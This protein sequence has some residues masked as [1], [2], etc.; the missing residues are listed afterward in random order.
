MD[1]MNASVSPAPVSRDRDAVRDLILSILA[2]GV[3][4]WFVG[5]LVWLTFA[6]INYAVP[7]PLMQS[8][9]YYGDI[10]DYAVSPDL[11]AATL[12]SAIAAIVLMRLAR[13][14]RATESESKNARLLARVL[15]YGTLAVVF[16]VLAGDLVY[17]LRG[18][19]AADLPMNAALKALAV[20]VY[21]LLAGWYLL[22]LRP[23]ADV[24]NS[25]L[26]GKVTGT[27]AAIVTLALVIG[28]GLANNRDGASLR[29]LR[30]DARRVQDL[31]QIQS[32]VISHWDVETGGPDS[33]DTLR[34]EFGLTLPKDPVTGED[35]R[36]EKIA[37][38]GFELCATFAA[39][40][41][42]K[43]ANPY[44]YGYDY[45][46]GYPMSAPV[47]G[48]GADVSL[49]EYGWTHGAGETCFERTPT[50]NRYPI[51]Y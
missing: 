22:G 34:S 21:S 31:Q 18:F 23:G 12:V 15:L 45:G 8:Y 30:L 28:G 5:S 46:Y 6:V 13:K 9:N 44:G 51:T 10:V 11:L 50:I 3:L 14:S 20:A 39:S 25:A 2:Y 27:V 40:S 1:T 29:D 41:T 42:E 48:G 24:A 38:T 33:L 36:Y 26:R 16:V 47:R 17:A 43:T 7:D 35:Y 37:A 4:Y 32:S 19:F 49:G